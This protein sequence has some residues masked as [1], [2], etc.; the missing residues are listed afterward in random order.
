MSL[1]S[2]VIELEWGGWGIPLRLIQEC[3]GFGVN[4]WKEGTSFDQGYEGRMTRG[5][6]R[7]VL[8]IFPKMFLGDHWRVTCPLSFVTTAWDVPRRIGPGTSK[9]SSHELEQGGRW[10]L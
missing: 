4:C 10:S 6:V 5:W 8:S 3:L 9:R 2:F 7:G 1:Y